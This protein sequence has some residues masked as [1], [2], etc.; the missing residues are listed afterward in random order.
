M[1]N[2]TPYS[3]TKSE[4]PE[5]PSPIQ[6]RYLYDKLR[7]RALGNN[8][9]SGIRVNQLRK[10]NR[11]KDKVIA[12]MR[13]DAQVL[14]NEKRALAEELNGLLNS[15]GDDVEFYEQVTALAHKLD[16]G[17]DKYYAGNG[18]YRG[19]FN[20]QALREAVVHFKTEFKRLVSRRHSDD[21]HP[22]ELGPASGADPT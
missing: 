19:G 7:R 4:F 20:I 13:A 11:I 5:Y 21:E 12:Q 15:I 14:V 9:G 16:E 1:A 18:K 6:L 3:I 10:Q 17:L 22:P 8:I 2:K